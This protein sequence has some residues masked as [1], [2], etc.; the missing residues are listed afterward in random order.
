VTISR[1]NDTDKVWTQLVPVLLVYSRRKQHAIHVGPPK[2][3]VGMKSQSAI[4]AFNAGKASRA[5]TGMRRS[6]RGKFMTS[7]KAKMDIVFIV[8]CK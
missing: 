1:W 4:V 6:R 8:P 7:R 5:C 3:P 2:L